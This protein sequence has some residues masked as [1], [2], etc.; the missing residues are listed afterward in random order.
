MN[1]D[2]LQKVPDAPLTRKQLPKKKGIARPRSSRS[3]SPQKRP[4]PNAPPSEHR[5][6]L[7]E[8]TKPK[9][10]AAPPLHRP[11]TVQRYPTSSKPRPTQADTRRLL[12]H[13]EPLRAAGSEVT[14]TVSKP[15]ASAVLRASEAEAYAPEPQQFFAP[16]LSQRTRKVSTDV[17]KVRRK[18]TGKI[19]RNLR[20]QNNAQ[21]LALTP[22]AP[23][24]LPSRK[25]TLPSAPAS[26]PAEP[27]QTEPVQAQPTPIETRPTESTTD[28]PMRPEEN[29]S[30][31]F[32]Y[33]S[34]E[35][36]KTEQDNDPEL[37]S[38][39]NPISTPNTLL[40][41]EAGTSMALLIV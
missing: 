17:P 28:E 33:S 2:Q 14:P 20:H 26:A 1:S 31:L 39:T 22:R 7:A 19:F 16:D 38:R 13:S 34:D 35:D 9:P 18:S 36:S 15:A 10:V 27:M 37:L 11:E 12:K 5:S 6:P 4:R 23:L 40:E 21:K 41:T 29:A 30:S 32:F 25:E 24:T 8:L 3:P